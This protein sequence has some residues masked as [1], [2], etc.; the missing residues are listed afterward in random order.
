RKRSHTFHRVLMRS[1]AKLSYQQAQF[2][3]GGRTDEVTEPLLKPVLE[4][5][6]AAYEALARARNER[7]PLDLDLPERKILLKPDGTVDRVVRPERLE[8]HR[9]IEEFM[10]LANVAAA[11]TCE[12]A[13]VPL[14]YRVHDEPSQEKLNALREFLATLD[15]SL[16]KG[17]A[18][19]PDGFNR[20][21]A[22]VKGR[23]V[24]RL[25]NEVVLRTQAQAE[26][27]PE[28]FGHFGLN[29]RRYAHFTSPIRR[30]ADLI[31]HRALIR[32]LKLGSDGLPEGTD[33]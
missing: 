5:L 9:L 11:E 28:N 3:I 16:P 27:S 26:Y 17:G 21:L 12:R 32:A 14:I 1:A 10:I 20:I 29:L 23:D 13:K 4:P 22:R 7:Q 8:A 33:I 18:L 24:E 2:A 30:Y 6:Y 25:V 31:V 15:I 19:R